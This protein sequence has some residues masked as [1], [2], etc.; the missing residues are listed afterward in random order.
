VAGNRECCLGV[1]HVGATA[2]IGDPELR[3][4]RRAQLL[5]GPP[6]RG[7]RLADL[8][9]RIEASSGA[10]T[11]LRRGLLSLL[12]GRQPGPH[13]TRMSTS[14]TVIQRTRVSAG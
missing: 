3:P 14:L 13:A 5:T 12:A 2:P 10:G 11:W 8:E 4:A 6:A 1:E 9:C 7:G